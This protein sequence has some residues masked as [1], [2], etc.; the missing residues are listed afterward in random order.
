MQFELQTYEVMEPVG[1][2]TERRTNV[3]SLVPVCF[4]YKTSEVYIDAS[5]SVNSNWE[6]ALSSW[7]V[8]VFIWLLGL[9]V[10]RDLEDLFCQWNLKIFCKVLVSFLSKLSGRGFWTVNTE[11]ESKKIF[12][13]RKCTW[14][15]GQ[16]ILIW[17]QGLISV[18]VLANRSIFIRCSGSACVVSH[19]PFIAFLNLALIFRRCCSRLEFNSCLGALMILREMTHQDKCC[20]FL[21]FLIVGKSLSRLL[22]FALEL[23][24]W[25]I[26]SYYSKLCSFL[27]FS[28]VHRI[29]HILVS[30][31]SFRISWKYHNRVPCTEEIV[32]L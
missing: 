20:V 22:G 30:K 5:Q 16:H 21:G 9:R 14:S 4:V 17:F 25:S 11:G 26:T 1:Q 6:V 24:K 27:K 3:Y 29:W 2:C 28:A 13:E 23:Y 19:M 31:W 15:C 32:V 18:Q 7:S 12:E 8:H 10:F